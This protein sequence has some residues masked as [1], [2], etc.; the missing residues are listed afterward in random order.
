MHNVH[1][2]TW[3]RANTLMCIYIMM[4]HKAKVYILTVYC[5]TIRT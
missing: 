2:V 3:N 5:A 1:V 4:V